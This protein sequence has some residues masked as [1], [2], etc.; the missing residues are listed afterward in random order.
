MKLAQRSS[1]NIFA[2]FRLSFHC[3]ANKYAALTLLKVIQ[4]N[5]NDINII[6]FMRRILQSKYLF[7]PKLSLDFVAKVLRCCAAG[8]LTVFWI[9]TNVRYW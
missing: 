4:R 2:Y 7:N 9:G 1:G 8:A 6:Q 5:M 3:I